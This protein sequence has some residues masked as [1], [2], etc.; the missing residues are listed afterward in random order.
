MP[1]QEEIN[2]LVTLQEK[3]SDQLIIIGIAIDDSKEK[4]EKFVQKE[5]INFPVLFDKN[6]QVKEMYKV[7]GYPESFFLNSEGKLQLL[8]DQ[9]SGLP[10]SRI[11]GPREWASN[12]YLKQFLDNK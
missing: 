11:R 6:S 7:K 3:L 5:K 8:T 1:C 10:E 9:I 12:F 2:D 4:I